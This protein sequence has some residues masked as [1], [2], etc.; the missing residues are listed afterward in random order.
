M[1]KE[2]TKKFLDDV[3]GRFGVIKKLGTGQSLYEVGNGAARIYV[4]YSKLHQGKKTFCGLRKVDL[5]DLEGYPSVICFLWDGQKTPLLIP[6]SDY[7]QVFQSVETAGDGQYKVQ[8]HVQEEG[9]E[10]YIANAG[11]FNVSDRAGWTPLEQLLELADADK[12]PELSHTQVQTLL[13]SIGARKGFDVWIPLGDR[14][15]LDWSMTDRFCCCESLPRGFDPVRSALQQ[16]DVVWVK[17]GSGQLLSLFEVE[18]STPIYSGLLR[19]NDV[20]LVAPTLKPRFNIVANYNRR[21]LFVD[22]LNRP[23]F[24]LSG[25]S[26]ACSFLEYVNVFGWHKRIARYGAEEPLDSGNG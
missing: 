4:R 21:D 9:T 14:S 1:P 19:F 2:V 22:Q 16:I 8:V 18:H 20:H 13:G 12:I 17:R 11:K 5:R 26:E 10:L 24:K 15:T 3:V 6:Y 7:E 23:T 25:L